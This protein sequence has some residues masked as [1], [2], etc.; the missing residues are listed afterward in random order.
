MVNQ[1][2]LFAIAIGNVLIRIVY[3]PLAIV[4]FGAS[5]LRNVRLLLFLLF[6]GG[7]FFF[8]GRYGTTVAREAHFLMTCRVGPYY[9]EEVRPILAGYIREFFNR[10]ICWY[11]AILYYPYAVGRRVVIPTL[12]EGGF[13]TT[14]TALAR[15]FGQLG[16]DVFV[17]W[18]ATGR[19]FSLE[20]DTTAICARWQTFWGAWQELLCYGCNDL[21]PYFTKLPIIPAFF[22][23]DQWKDDQFWCFMSNVFNGNAVMAQRIVYVIREIIYPTQPVRPRFMFRR[24]FD[25]YCDASTCFWKSME[26][27]LQKTW[28]N[29][30]PFQLNWTDLLCIFDRMTCAG[31]RGVYILFNL[32]DNWREVVTHFTGGS[33]TFWT[34]EVRQDVEELIGLI[35]TPSYFAP[36]SEALPNGQPNLTITPYQLLSTLPYRPNGRPNPLFNKTSAGDCACIAF[37]R[38]L[39]D[40]QNNGT[41]CAEQFNG[42]LLDAIDPCCLGQEIFT[43]T[44]DAASTIFELTLHTQSINDF[45]LFLDRQPFT[46]VIKQDMVRFWRCFAQIFLTV[47][48][49]GS[50]LLNIVAEIADFFVCAGELVFRMVVAGLTLP[51]FDAFLPGYCNYLTCPGNNNAISQTIAFLDRLGDTTNPNGLINCLCFT[52]NTGFNVQFAGCK[53]TTCTP[54]GFVQPTTT[55]MTRQVFGRSF[56]NATAYTGEYAFK[57]TPIMTYGENAIPNSF[58]FTQKRAKWDG[59]LLEPLRVLDGRLDRFSEHMKCSRAVANNSLI[60][61]NFTSGVVDCNDNP[62]CFN[63]CCFPSKTI[64]LFA[65]TLAFAA[66]GLNAVLQS[67][68]NAAGSDYWTGDAC[69]AGGDCFQSDA[70]ILVVRAIAPI[71]CLCEFLKLLIPPQGF[72]DPCCGFRLAAELISCAIQII[73]NIGNSVSGDS[74]NFTYIRDPQFLRNDFDIVLD[75]ALRLFDCLCDFI[76]TIFA[77]AIAFN[78]IERGFDPCCVFR[79]WFRAIL[80]GFRL[81]FRTIMALATPEE[82]ASQCY[83]YVNGFNNARPMCP[84]G[85]NDV[86][87]VQHL[88]NITMILLAPPINPVILQRCVVEDDIDKLPIDSEGLPTCLCRMVNALLAMVFKIVGFTG[89][90]SAQPRCTINLCC[91]IYNYSAIWKEVLDVLAQLIATL[92]QNWEYKTFA[93]EEFF[94]PQETLYFFFCDEYG[95][96]PFIAGTNPPLGNPAFYGNTNTAPLVNNA[97]PYPGLGGIINPEFENAKCGRLEPAIQ[98]FSRLAGGC[99]C[100]N[101]TA[102]YNPGQ[103]GNG[104]A[105][106][107]DDIL[108]WFVGFASEN[109]SIFPFQFEWP[110][111]LCKG[112]PDPSNPGIVQPAAR[113]LEVLIRQVIVLVRNIGNPSFWAHQG[114]TLTDNDYAMNELID[115]FEDIRKTF[116]NRFLGPFADAMCTLVTNMGCLLSMI[117]GT[118]CTRDRY[119]MLSSFT[120]YYFEAVIRLVSLIEGVVKLFTQ[121]PP[122]LCVGQANGNQNYAPGQGTTGQTGALVPTC[123]QVGGEVDYFSFNTQQLGRI[124]NSALGFIVDALIGV[125]RYTCTEIC[126]GYDP[127]QVNPYGFDGGNLIIGFRPQPTN[128]AAIESQKS[129]CDCWNKSPFTGIVSG[130]GSICGF[131]TCDRYYNSGLGTFKCPLNAQT[132]S[133]EQAQQ[134]PNTGQPVNQYIANSIQGGTC[135]VCSNDTSIVPTDGSVW[136]RPNSISWET[137]FPQFPFLP[138]QLPFQPNGLGCSVGNLVSPQA[139]SILDNQIGRGLFIAGPAQY[140]SFSLAFAG[141]S[142]QD[143]CFDYPNYSSPAPS[144]TP[145]PT[146]FTNIVAQIDYIFRPQFNPVYPGSCRFLRDVCNVPRATI[147]G[148][149]PQESSFLDIVCEPTGGFP[150]TGFGR[151]TPIDESGVTISMR[152]ACQLCQMAIQNNTSFNGDLHP[153]NVQHACDRTYCIVQKGLCKNDQMVP[154]N[155]DGAVLDG[156]FMA[157]GKYVN[158]LMQDLFGNFPAAVVEILLQAMSVL[159]QV[160]GGIIRFVTSVVLMVLSF[161]TMDLSFAAISI[162]LRFFETVSRFIQ[163]FSQ[164]VSLGYRFVRDM[165]SGKRSPTDP[166]WGLNSTNNPAQNSFEELGNFDDAHDCI[167]EVNPVPCFCRV[168]NMRP[169]CDPNTT[170][171]AEVMMYLRDHFGGETDCDMLFYHLADM[172]PVN[173]LDIEYAQRYQAAECVT[174]RAKGEHYRFMSNNFLKADFFYSPRSEAGLFE[175]TISAVR[176]QFTILEPRERKIRSDNFK[177]KFKMDRDYF[178]RFLNS[179]GNMV[180]R[181][182]VEEQHMPA[183][184]PIME[185]LLKLEMHN[186]MYRVGYYHYLIEEAQWSHFTEKIGYA[187][188]HWPEVKD[189]IEELASKT[190]VVWNR[191]KPS[192]ETIKQFNEEMPMAVRVVWDGTL[193]RGLRDNLPTFSWP[194]V[195]FNPPTLEDIAV[196]PR[197]VWTDVLQHNYNVGM[198][199]MYS[200]LHIIWPH[201]TSRDVH[202]RFILNGNCRIADGAVEVGVEL[203]DYCLNEFRENIP[204]LRESELGN[205]LARSS[206]LRPRSFH[207]RFRGKFRWESSGSGS[208]KRPRLDYIPLEERVLVHAHSYRRAVP[209]E[210]PF[211]FLV[212][213]VGDLFG[214]DLLQTLDNFVVDFQAWIANPN[215]DI[216]QWPNVGARYI[217][218]FLS[219]CE[220]PENLNCSIGIGL[221]EAL[222]RVGL[223]YVIVLV[224]LGLIFPGVLSILSLFLNF[225]LYVLIVMIVAWHYSPAC[226]ALFPSAEFSGVG[227]TLPILPIPLNIFPTLP[228]CLWDDIISILDSIFATCYTW[229]PT[230]WLDGPQCPTCDDKL[231]LPDCVQVGVSTPLS[232]LVYWGYRLMGMAWCDIMSGVSSNIAFQWIPGF[233]SGVSDTCETIRTASPTQLDRMAVCGVFS[234]G[235]LAFFAAGLLVAGLF[236]VSVVPAIVNLGHAIA[237]TIPTLPGYDALIGQGARQGSFTIDGEDEEPIP[238]EIVDNGPD[239]VGRLARA[240]L[241]HQKT[242]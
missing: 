135:N 53:N 20:L 29:F 70:T 193:L 127:N 159:W 237:L 144:F 236:I 57:L 60:P 176:R 218:R 103:S 27:I 140:T 200:A 114:G 16:K 223:I 195:R 116:I 162:P 14:V 122:G 42:T 186:F 52:L 192:K 138:I 86:G 55:T 123:S 205:Y 36:V 194:R 58:Q 178:Y 93:G 94:M 35:G 97:G 105:N 210:G 129:V 185:P 121:E 128:P 168:L 19:F 54:V 9:Q 203:V 115:N 231:G 8:V 71:E 235:T 134:A 5:L 46:S 120:R 160:S 156:V 82:P 216:K 49:Y 136:V 26:N 197:Y 6:V 2:I 50:C 77:V 240:F 152:S 225:I 164:P 72:G 4:A 51:Y 87:I 80:E 163:I 165:F 233:F 117:L 89:D 125:G 74:P 183:N 219:V 83:L 169:F 153:P 21:C 23:S 179:R 65:H 211:G 30:I 154:C 98:A 199:M 12:R 15:L 85:I 212:A 90:F 99:L 88:R 18:I 143:V 119:N 109:S 155:P 40:P 242:Q 181:Y 189:S 141:D 3:L 227:V 24:A 172:A 232:T 161:F 146:P 11:N 92:W 239:L 207:A 13:G 112:G 96:E 61:L 204:A 64:Q 230:G 198:R 220:F 34:E 48:T 184:S 208:W 173:W 196:W 110:R 182:Y 1:F 131:E 63:L 148:L 106:V 201:Y 69:S 126:P 158:C 45:V 73:I 157:F 38:L 44:A 149:T 221:G 75:I 177:K 111:C 67:R 191:H 215:T 209:P 132:C 213:W 217:P 22:G 166:V 130:Q 118:T 33:T 145:L 150:G 39:C 59:S 43:L 188:D 62:P 180:K 32:L 133:R 91:I 167:D 7:I 56:Y 37:T 25:L 31:I 222:W 190:R 174:K 28:D 66:R 229:I 95:S 238:I 234:F 47:Q 100:S 84:P 228:E 41:T 79:V 10:I 170:T 142:V 206:H 187:Q 104:F 226:I 202:E 224:V 241:P 17:D 68:F 113:A 147:S 102:Q 139:Q 78:D 175:S 101:S 81:L 124:I 171:T 107:L 214:I 137:A 76:R 108:R 151:F